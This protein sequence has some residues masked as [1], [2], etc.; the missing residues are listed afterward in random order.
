[1][2]RYVA[3]ISLTVATVTT[4]GC[5]CRRSV[6]AVAGTTRVE[7]CLQAPMFGPL[8]GSRGPSRP[9]RIANVRAGFGSSCRRIRNASS[10]VQPADVPLNTTP[11]PVLSS[12]IAVLCSSKATRHNQLPVK[13]MNAAVSPNSSNMLDRR[14]ANPLTSLLCSAATVACCFFRD[15]E[16]RIAT[17]SGTHARRHSGR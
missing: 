6:I 9:K 15:R 17:A 10:S 11:P 14:R 8:R 7:T 13:V 1:M 16:G 5:C 4:V 2:E 3:A 12:T